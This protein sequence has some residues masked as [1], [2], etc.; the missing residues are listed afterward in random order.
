MMSDL[1]A[2]CLKHKLILEEHG[3][4][5]FGRPCVGLLAKGGNY[6]DYKPF[7]DDPAND[8]T[9]P[10]FDGDFHPPEETQN[11]YH[12]HTCVAVLVHDDDYDKALIELWH[13]VKK[14][15]GVGVVVKEYATG[16]TG[17]QAVISGVTGY[18][19]ALA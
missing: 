9:V 11:A 15:D 6:L 13:W 19:L 12:K 10:G 8:Y 5:G 2:F 7:V 16:A 4:V 14:L 17:L 18:A 1:N 3:E